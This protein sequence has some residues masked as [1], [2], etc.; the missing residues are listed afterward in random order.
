[1]SLVA[2]KTTVLA[3]ILASDAPI[4]LRMSAV[5]LC[6]FGSMPR[7]YGLSRGRDDAGRPVRERSGCWC[8][9]C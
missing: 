8:V 9:L 2:E 7:S 4:S 1:M 5:C 6:I 3:G